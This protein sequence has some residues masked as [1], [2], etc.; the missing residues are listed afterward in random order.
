MDSLMRE[1]KQ[2]LEERRAAL[3]HL[4]ER[5][6]A[7]ERSGAA[8]QE[9]RSDQIASDEMSEIVD[10]LSSREQRELHEVESALQRI[11]AGTYGRCEGCGQAIGRQRLRALPETRFC[12]S[13]STRANA[14]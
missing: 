12:M 9:D 13:C 6:V 4:V 3:L 1:A 8:L 14:A 10:R 5:G 11:V 7:E 2:T